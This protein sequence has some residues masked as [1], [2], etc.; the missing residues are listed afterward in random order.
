MWLSSVFDPLMCLCACLTASGHAPDESV[1]GFLGGIS[2]H[3]WIRASVSSWTVCGCTWQHQMH[4]HITFHR[5]SSG[6]RSGERPFRNCFHTL[7]TPGRILSC[8]RRNPGPTTPVSGLTVAL[9]YLVDLNMEA[10][11]TLQRQASLDYHW[12]TTKLAAWYS[13]SFVR[14][15]QFAGGHFVGLWQC[16]SWHKG[17]DTGPAAGLMTFLRPCPALLV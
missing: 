12:P 7:A 16:S 15:I 1:D 5:C 2:S 8:A 11:V 6:F 3:T 9:R 17:A 4:W 10:C 13:V 14:N